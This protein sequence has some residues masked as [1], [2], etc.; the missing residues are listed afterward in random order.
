MGNAVQSTETS[1]PAQAQQDIP[2]ARIQQDLTEILASS[3]F[4]SSK[5]SQD[6]LRYIVD[7][8]LSGH[9]EA[10]KE[11]VIGFE[12]FGRRPDYDTN[13]DPIVRARVAEVRKRLALYYQAEPGKT[14]RFSVP[15]GSFRAI[16]QRIDKEPAPAASIP[17]QAR[18]SNQQTPQTAEPDL[19]TVPQEAPWRATRRS[20]LKFRATAVWI[21]LA[22]AVLIGAFL[23]QHNLPSSESRALNRFWSPILDNP[24][25]TLIYVGGNA[26]YELS[27]SY[28]DSYYQQHPQSKTEEM[29]FESYIDFPPGTKIDAQDLFPAKDTFVTI[30]DVAAITKIESLLVHHDRQF[31]TRFGSDVTYGDLREAPTVLIGAHN[32][33][34]TLTLTG[35]LRY[36]FSGRNAIVDRMDPRKRWSTPDSF[37]EDYAIVSRVLNSKTGNMVIAVAGVGYAGTQAAAEFVTNPQSVSTLLKSLPKGWEKKNLQIVLHTSVTNQIP[38]PAEVVAVYSW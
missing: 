21:I 35:S 25:T 32:N 16:F 15:P 7:R 27:P 19:L 34:W 10:L 1:P 36:V 31:D 23:F 29:G 30:G 3:P 12:V 38:G 37:T 13:N 33:S 24:Q 20:A 2:A 4:R 14:V 8:S 9:A 18:E 5:Q 17:A 22:A 11:R 6:L 28:L 26:V